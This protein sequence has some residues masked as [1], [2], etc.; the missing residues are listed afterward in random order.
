MNQA[1]ELYQLRLDDYRRKID[2]YAEAVRG[3]ANSYAQVVPHIP[4]DALATI[5]N[6]PLIDGRIHLAKTKLQ[7]DLCRELLQ[8]GKAPSDEDLDVLIAAIPKEDYL[9]LIAARA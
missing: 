7:F 6:S 1:L 9:R 8:I 5:A 3:T 2:E 4:V